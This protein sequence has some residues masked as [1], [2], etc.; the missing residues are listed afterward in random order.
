LGSPTLN[1]D[2]STFV[3]GGVTGSTPSGAESFELDVRSRELRMGAARIRLQEQPF[4]ILR[5]MLEQPGRVVTRDE[6]C[7]RLWPAG[8]FIDV[9][10]SLNAAVK[11]LRD[12]LGDEADNP[13][14]VETLPR[15][16][17]RFI[18]WPDAGPEPQA[19]APG[20]AASQAR[21][22]VLPFV[23]LTPDECRDCFTDG[24]T[25]E[26]IAQLAIAGRG[27]LGVVA[28]W[29]SMAFRGPQQRAREI[30]ALLG[31]DYLVEGSVRQEGERVRIAARLVQAADETLLWSEAFD[32]RRTPALAAQRD[33]A[34]RI[35][36]SLTVQLTCAG[37]VPTRTRLALP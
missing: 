26:T 20:P 33:A 16:G 15:R 34:A 22:A 5:L 12:A 1:Q 14:F 37:G 29:P 23:N 19:G 3:S 13:K 30:G 35:A 21:V 32:E 10:H 9:E 11:R 18:G 27:R 28:Q 17:Y 4:E 2:G 7:A 6:L 8:T 36:H 25:E 31:T 24:L